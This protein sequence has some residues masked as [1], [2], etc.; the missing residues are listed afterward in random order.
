MKERI[1]QQISHELKQATRL[2]VKIVII[3]IVITLI[4]FFMAMG[5]AASTVGSV[6]GELTAGLTRAPVTMSFNVSPTIVMFILIIAVFAINWFSVR[7]LLN[8]K[9]ERAKLTEGLMKLYKDE[10]VDQYYDGSIFKSYETRY[11]IFS[12]ILA[13]LGA[14]SIIAPLVIFIDKLTKL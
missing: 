10:G 4:L 1:H 7:A 9:K 5:F 2:D 6:T 14:V 8:N 11:N 13:I 12:V 3:G